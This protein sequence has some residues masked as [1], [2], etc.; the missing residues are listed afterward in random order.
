MRHGPPRALRVACT[1]LGAV[2]VAAP[3]LAAALP[4][5]PPPSAGQEDPEALR[6]TLADAVRLAFEKN[7]DIRVVSYDRTSAQEQVTTAEGTF[8]PTVFFGTPSPTG[9]LLPPQSTAFGGGGT[10]GG[11]GLGSTE[12]PT[13]SALAGADVSISDDFRLLVDFG[14]DLPWGMRYDLG[15]VTSRNESNS[16]FTSLNPAWNNTLALSVVQP[17]LR[18]R[19]REA[20]AAELRIARRGVA[21]SEAAFRGQ[22]EGVLLEVEQA[23]WDLVFAEGD[24]EVKEESLRL[25]EE[26]LERTR[27]QVEVGLIAP[28][29]ETQ[30]EVAMAN[31]ET[32]LIAARNVVDDARDTLRALLRADAL[33]RGWETPLVAVDEPSVAAREVDVAAAVE[34]AIESRP[35]LAGVR[36]D[37]SV[38]EARVESARNALLPRLDLLGQVSWNGIG[39]DL[40]IREEGFGGDVIDVVDGGYFDA[41]DQLL[42]FGFTSWRVGFNVSYDI[43]NHRARGNYA[44]ATAGEDRARTELQRLRQQVTL[45]V[46]SAARAVEAAAEAVESTT[47]AVGLAERQLQIEQDRF[48]VGM[49]TNFEVLEFQEELSRARTRRLQALVDYRKARAGLD[50]ARGTLPERFGIRIATATG[51]GE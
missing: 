27:A 44:Q 39:G 47:R 51:D 25:A 20:A 12:N 17:L 16:V 32:D 48:E 35:E 43:G 38:Q 5:S 45:E 2:L 36:A 13:A 6:L 40:L 21:V 31:R 24:L 11:I 41:A 30:A 46:R 9:F 3:G 8:D 29:Q 4:A 19:G 50:R 1:M 10:L 28:V 7:L 26:Q 23:Y 18:G 37:I 14:Q 15:Y 22:V 34:T 33:P 42:S 49:S